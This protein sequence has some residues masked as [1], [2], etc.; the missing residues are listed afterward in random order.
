M[1]RL[2]RLVEY[3]RGVY[4]KED[5]KTLYDRYLSDIKS[6]TPEELIMVENEQLKLG[7]T[8]K[9]MLTFVDKLINVFYESLSSHAYKGQYPDFI[10]IL[11]AENKGLTN[12]LD[13]FKVHLYASKK[14]ADTLIDEFV[15]SLLLYNPHMEKIENIIFSYMEK[16]ADHFD[17]LKIMWSLHDDIRRSIKMLKHSE[18]WIK[19]VGKLYFL[20]HGAVKKQELILFPVMMNHI[21][22][23]SF[24]GMYDASFE[25]GFSYVEV[26]ERRERKTSMN[27]DALSK[28]IQTETGS[29][30]LEVLINILN[31]LPIDFTFVDE[32][33]QVAYFNDS[34]ERIFPRSKSVIGRNVR[35]CHPPESVHVVEDILEAFKNK[36]KD[37]AEFW[38]QMKGLMIYIYYIPIYDNNGNYKGTLEISQELSKVRSLEGERRLLDWHN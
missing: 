24:E 2:E 17:G 12:I 29:L 34:K 6:I 13:D 27:F 26:P 36:T 5:G 21:D 10:Q 7:L 15:D 23:P 14:P 37:K 19:D 1:T 16:K 31:A 18:S 33:D 11:I 20:L 28:I 22:G 4:N 9:D 35:N 8:P 32:S 38:I 3:C 25:Y 30:S